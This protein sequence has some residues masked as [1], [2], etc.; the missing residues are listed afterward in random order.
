MKTIWIRHGKT[1][2]NLEYRYIG[3]ATDEP[4]CEEGKE[5]LKRLLETKED[6]LSS[7][8]RLFVSPM[9]RCIETAE[10]LYPNRAF[11]ICPD[12]RECDFGVWEGKNYKE[13][14]GDPAYQAW[15]DS[16]GTL[17]FPKG[18]APEAFHKRC[19]AGFLEAIALCGEREVP[20]FLVH[21]GTIMAVLSEFAIP[22]QNQY[23][24][25]VKNARGYVTEYD[26]IGNVMRI[27]KKL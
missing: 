13:L 15:I 18:E 8:T 23:A 12:L 17:P 7:C 27:V 6:T 14:N 16:G 26:S 2:G 4:L 22:K 24:Y 5:E 9:K 3:K 19:C 20:A 21:G 10:I 1:A 25:Q 11:T